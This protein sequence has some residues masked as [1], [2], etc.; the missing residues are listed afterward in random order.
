MAVL[1]SALGSFPVVALLIAVTAGWT[2][3][4]GRMVDAGLLVVALLVTWAAVDIAKE[5]FDRPRPPGSHVA[6]RGPGYPSGHAAFAVAWLACAVTRAR[7][8]P[9][10][11]R[12]I[13]TVAVAVVLMAAIA[14]SRVFLRAHYLADVIG[15][16]ALGGTI[17]GLA[18]IATVV[19]SHLRNNARAAP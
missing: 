17:F 5:Y 12:R 7:L 3:G 15:G 11:G 14:V 6:T 16:L 4:R 10:T 1:V 9:I 2:A 18:G 19:V 13:A 8:A